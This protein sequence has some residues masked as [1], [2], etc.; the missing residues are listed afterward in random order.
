MAHKYKI[1]HF[2]GHL[3]FKDLQVDILKGLSVF[4]AGIYVTFMKFRD[5][6]DDN[7]FSM[8]FTQELI[9][10]NRDEI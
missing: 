2:Q 6:I 5:D 7:A 8:N 1:L 10:K 4:P 9:S 3:E